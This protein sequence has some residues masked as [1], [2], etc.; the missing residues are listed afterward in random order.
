MFFENFGGQ[1]PGYPLVAGLSTNPFRVGS[2]T[3]KKKVQRLLREKFFVTR[4]RHH[5]IIG[6]CV[7]T[8]LRSYPPHRAPGSAERSSRLLVVLH[9]VFLVRPQVSL[10]RICGARWSGTRR[11]TSACGHTVTG[12]FRR[13]ASLS[14]QTA[15]RTPP[16]NLKKKFEGICRRGDNGRSATAPFCPLPD[17]FIEIY[18]RPICQR[19]S[20]D[21]NSAA[22]SL[23]SQILLFCFFTFN[24]FYFLRGLAA[25]L[26]VHNIESSTPHEFLP[27]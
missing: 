12:R 26:R 1:L 23:R 15:P 18:R 25:R 5:L 9:G 17:P 4:Q 10:T 22:F 27:V 8:R 7:E 20:K 21:L 16:L 6:C 3:C 2:L 24:D 14:Q 11:V 13:I 19:P